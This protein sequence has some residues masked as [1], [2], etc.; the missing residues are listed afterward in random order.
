M[1]KPEQDAM[2]TT[3]TSIEARRSDRHR[4]SCHPELA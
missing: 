3:T 1:L 2:D 4:A